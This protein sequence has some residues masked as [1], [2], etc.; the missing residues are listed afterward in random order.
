[1]QC[2]FHHFCL[3]S[4]SASL[5]AWSLLREQV[6]ME[7]GNGLFLSHV[8]MVSRYVSGFACLWK[9]AV[10]FGTTK[11]QRERYLRALQ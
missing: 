3:G 6:G 8:F 10:S 4:F 1:M 5:F 7:S 11:H 2:P 9:L